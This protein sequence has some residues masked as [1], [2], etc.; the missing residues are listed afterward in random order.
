[1]PFVASGMKAGVSIGPW[2][3]WIVPV[4]RGSVAGLDLEAQPLRG[5]SQP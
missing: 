3:V 1:M 4:A 2:A 5:A